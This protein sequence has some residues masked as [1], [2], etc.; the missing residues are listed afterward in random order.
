MVAEGVVE[1]L[2]FVEPG[3]MGWRE[4]GARLAPTAP[5]VVSCSAGSVARIAVVDQVYAPQVM[6]AMPESFQFVDVV[7]RVFRLNACC[8]HPAAVDDQDV[9]DVDRPMPRVLELLLF[10]RARYRS[11]DR[12]TF[13]DL[14]VGDLVGADH[15]I[16]PLDQAVSVGVAP[17]DLLCPLL[18]LGVQASRPPVTCPVRLQVDLVQDS[19]YGP[20]A[21]RRH[22]TVSDRLA[23]QVRAG[24]LG[25]VQALGHGLQA[26][27]FDHLG[28]LQGG[29]SRSSVPIAWVVRGARI[30]PSVRID[31]TCDGRSIHHTGSRR[32]GFAFEHRRRSPRECGL[33][34]PDTKAGSGCVQFVEGPGCL[35]ERFQSDAVFDHAWGKLLAEK[36]HA[37]QHNISPEFRALLMAGDTRIN[38]VSRVL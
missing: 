15:P 34:G 4:P 35:R 28:T 5:E 9:Q 1:D 17:E 24:P 14:V 7:R 20:L 26:G 29:K 19:A 18:E 23:G 21:E 2:C 30:T 10:D 3:G 27:Q 22:D 12:V 32:P 36:G 6:M 31:G 37:F 16:A 13:K 25:N 8:F 33:D 11:T 38:A